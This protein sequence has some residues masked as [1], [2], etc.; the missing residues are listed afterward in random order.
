[1]FRSD[2]ISDG[3]VE[4]VQ[5]NPA[6]TPQGGNPENVTMA[7]ELL[8]RLGDIGD[9]PLEDRAAAYAQLHDELRTHLE[10]GDSAPR[11]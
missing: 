5:Q 6:D 8:S 9:L 10:G 1:M 3:N 4:R 11:P 7:E 2:C